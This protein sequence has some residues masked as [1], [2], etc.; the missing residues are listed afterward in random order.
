MQAN[1]NNQKCASAEECDKTKGLTCG[2]GG[3]C[4]CKD[5]TV[6]WNEKQTSCG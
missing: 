1:A 2:K 5:N 4:Q 6:Y 3:V